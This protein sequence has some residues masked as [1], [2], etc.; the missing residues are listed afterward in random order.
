MEQINILIIGNCGVGKTYVMQSLIKKFKC[1]QTKKTDLLHYNTNGWLNITGK[2]GGGEFQGSDKL[3]M[4]VMLSLKE[5]L[6]KVKGVSIYEGDR[7]TNSN[8]IKQAKPYIIKING[9]G[10]KGR[11]IRG[12]T[13][14][15]RQIKSIETR[16]NNV[17]YNFSFEDSSFV[18]KYFCD[19]F[20]SQSIKL[21]NQV[22]LNDKNNYVKK[23]QKLF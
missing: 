3:S 21:I 16:V 11:L 12:S 18:I 19:L 8:F 22:L 15:T 1:D 4:S 2:Y 20:N 13:Q 14:T 17:D 5:Y 9:N 6:N 7:F 23:Q 10:S